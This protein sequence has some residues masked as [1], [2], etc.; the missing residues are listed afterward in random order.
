[1]REKHAGPKLRMEKEA[2]ELAALKQQ[3]DEI[4][5]EES[6]AALAAVNT[7]PERAEWLAAVERK[8]R[9]S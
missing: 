9:G 2:E 4:V 5:A 8:S 6:A 1:M 7:H 3:C